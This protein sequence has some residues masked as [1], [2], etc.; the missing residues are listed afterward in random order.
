M[1]VKV[2]ELCMKIDELERELN[3][4]SGT[5]DRKLRV[6]NSLPCLSLYIESLANYKVKPEKERDKRR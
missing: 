3:V 2:N 1:Q 6:L 4:K 5:V